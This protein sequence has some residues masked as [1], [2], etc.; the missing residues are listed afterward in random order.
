M[1]NLCYTEDY[2]SQESKTKTQSIHDVLCNDEMKRQFKEY[3]DSIYSAEYILFLEDYTEYINLFS[4]PDIKTTEI[5]DRARYIEYRYIIPMSEHQLNIS[6]SMSRDISRNLKRIS[7]PRFSIL[8]KTKRKSE[9]IIHSSH[10]RGTPI[11]GIDKDIPKMQ[12]IRN[13]ALYTLFDPVYLEV[14]NI[15]QTCLLPN[16][17]KIPQPKL[18]IT[19]SSQTVSSL[20]IDQ[21]MTPTHV[22][23]IITDI[24]PSHVSGVMSASSA[25]VTNNTHFDFDLDESEIYVI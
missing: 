10:H 25:D 3:M 18:S 24:T 13:K 11:L 15:L 19:I 7:N 8:A 22:S 9:I 1:G 23:G 21:Q 16:F 5:I 12:N 4:K 17:S 20:I 14:L 2:K 6:D